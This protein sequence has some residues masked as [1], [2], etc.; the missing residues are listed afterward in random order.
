MWPAATGIPSASSQSSSCAR[1]NAA[2]SLSTSKAMFHEVSVAWA[3]WEIT[4]PRASACSTPEETSRLACPGECPDVGLTQ[5]RPHSRKEL[6]Q[7]EKWP[8]DV[9]QR[10]DL[11][12]SNNEPLHDAITTPAPGY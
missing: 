11:D 1:V 2:R 8:L 5:V 6:A 10:S 9:G 3:G 4:S 12:L 7:P